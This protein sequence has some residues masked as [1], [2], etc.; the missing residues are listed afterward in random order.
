MSKLSKTTKSVVKRPLKG[1]LKRSA[2]AL[3]ANRPHKPNR[4][5][6]HSTALSPKPALQLDSKPTSAKSFPLKITS[7]VSASTKMDKVIAM[8]RDPKGATIAA[9]TKATGW[10]NHSVRGFLASV[11]RKRLK[12]TLISEKVDGERR[13]RIGNLKKAKR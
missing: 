7:P 5:K 12:L 11:V 13:Y 8:L 9:I 1:V 10:Q 3:P 4:D 2:K 6:I